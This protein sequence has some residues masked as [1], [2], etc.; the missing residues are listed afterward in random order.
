MFIKLRNSAE[1]K[2][3]ANW[4]NTWIL[5]EQ[6]RRIEEILK[7][8]DTCIAALSSPKNKECFVLFEKGLNIT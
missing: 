5:S 1:W 8:D 7:T 3:Y 6:D 4:Q 2:L